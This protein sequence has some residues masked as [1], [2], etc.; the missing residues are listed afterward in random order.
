MN[1]LAERTERL[2]M[3]S[4]S[5]T[6]SGTG[7]KIA[8]QTLAEVVKFA[9]VMCRADIALP[10]HLRGNAGACMA[11]AMQAL[12]WQLSPF[13]VAS[14]SYS[15]N[16]AIAYEAQLIA[17]VVNTR[18]GIKGRLRYA[19]EG[20][21]GD[22][23]CTVTGVLDDEECVYRSPTIG[24]IT[25]KNS[26]LWKSDPQQQLGYFAA[27]SW[28]RRH[29]PEVILGVYDRD[30]AEEFR[31]PDHA[32]DITPRPT[33]MER[34][35]ASANTAPETP[36]G[37]QE[38]FSAT[39]VHQQPESVLTGDILDNEQAS[40]PSPLSGSDV[41]DASTNAAV[42]EHTSSEPEGAPSTPSGS[43]IPEKEL[44]LLRRFAKDVFLLASKSETSGEMMTRI[45]NRWINIELLNVRSDAGR[46][47][48][49]SIHQSVKAIMK[50]EVSYET[51]VE[52]HAEGLSCPVEELIGGGNG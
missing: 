8:P 20:E 7:S 21:G 9:E 26:P 31:G 33:V 29:C 48:V 5:V 11:V 3:D 38:G 46:D 22:M 42:D 27:R 12:E 41:D 37:E 15:V 36:S 4:V 23:T 39:G 10:K 6:T 35:R 17:A 32:K 2:P 52:F 25:T 43:S 47:A 51:A 45:I 40:E 44:L 30:E 34:L 24:S 18:S 19:F 14:K 1:Q 49:K 16:G 13:A 28:A 50:D